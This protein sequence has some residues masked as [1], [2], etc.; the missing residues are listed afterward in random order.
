MSFIQALIGSVTSAGGGAPLDITTVGGTRNE[1]G[2][3]SYHTWTSNDTFTLNTAADRDIEWCMIGG[4]GSA[5]KNN[6]STQ[7]GGGGGAG[8]RVAGTYSS[9]PAGTWN[10]LIGAGG[11]GNPAGTNPS[12]WWYGNQGSITKSQQTSGS[13]GS[14]ITANGGGF[15]GAYQHLGVYYAGGSGGCGGGGSGAYGNSGAGGTVSHYSGSNPPWATSTGFAGGQG[16]Y[17]SSGYV[18]GGGGGGIGSTGGLPSNVSPWN[19]YGSPLN[20]GAGGTGAYHPMTAGSSTIDSTTGVGGSGGG[21]N[22]AGATAPGGVAASN[23][24][25]S[26]AAPAN[27]GTGSSSGHENSDVGAGGSGYIILRWVTLV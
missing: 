14:T 6:P 22:A 23:S 21:G 3:Y 18:A 7:P 12:P 27:T 20:S 8:E 2:I 15:G 16:S 4:G 11:A 19:F 5:G 10:T 26:A 9:M 24:G 17:N 1:V 25:S 13:G